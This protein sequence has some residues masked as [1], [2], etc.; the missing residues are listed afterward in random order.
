M[1]FSSR[2]ILWCIKSRTHLFTNL[3]SI[4]GLLSNSVRV[5]PIKL[6]IGMLYQMNNTFRNTVFSI[7]VDVPLNI[8]QNLREHTCVGVNFLIKLY[9]KETPAQG[10]SCKFWEVFKNTFLNRTLLLA[11][12]DFL[13]IHSQN[14]KLLLDS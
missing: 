4:V 1:I 13:L 3:S 9:E 14:H 5:Y 8:S 11:T 10:F 7:F 2:H 12:S 6:K